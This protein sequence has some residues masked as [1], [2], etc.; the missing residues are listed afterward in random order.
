MAFLLHDALR[1]NFASREPPASFDSLCSIQC[2]HLW[3][4]TSA[5]LI[6]MLNSISS[7]AQTLSKFCWQRICLQKYEEY[8]VWSEEKLARLGLM[9]SPILST[10]CPSWLYPT[11][12]IDIA[13]IVIIIF[14]IV[15]IVIIT[16]VISVIIMITPLVPSFLWSIL[17]N[18]FFFTD[19]VDPSK[20]THCR[21]H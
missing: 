2:G 4:D 7:E 17:I 12:L 21:F 13:I 20:G 5:K 19:L 1:K 6:L 9:P 11:H 10:S 18:C 14:V 16:I 15:I 8:T 3:E